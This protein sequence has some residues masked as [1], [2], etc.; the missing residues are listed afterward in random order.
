MGKERNTG[1]RSPGSSS[2]AE[3]GLEMLK[4]RSFSKLSYQL[5]FWFLVVGA[6]LTIGQSVYHFYLCKA[7][8]KQQTLSGLG[9]PEYLPEFHRSPEDKDAPFHFGRLGPGCDR[10]LRGREKD[11][12]SPRGNGRRRREGGKNGRPEPIRGA[13]HPG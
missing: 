4:W 10:L 1:A 13:R 6:L 5:V 7:A 12:G 9:G 11:R 2:R 8:L 3:R